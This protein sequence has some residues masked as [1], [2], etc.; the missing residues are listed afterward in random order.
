[1]QVLPSTSDWIASSIGQNLNPLNPRDNVVAGVA[2]IRYN[3][4]NTDDL[5]TAIAAY[6]Q[7]LGG[8][9]KYGM[10]EDTKRYV[11]SVKAHMKN[12]R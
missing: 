10:Y 9:K 11:A 7:G 8:V 2:V 3:L 6:Y 4:N 12:F 1:M 5:D